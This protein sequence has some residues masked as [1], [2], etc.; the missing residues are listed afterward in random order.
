[1]VSVL[2]YH[3]KVRSFLTFIRRRWRRLFWWRWWWW[4]RKYWFCLLLMSGFLVF[5]FV[6]STLVPFLLTFLDVS[7]GLAAVRLIVR[8]DVD[9]SAHP[10]SV[11]VID[12][13]LALRV[14]LGSYNTRTRQMIL[15]LLSG[16]KKNPNS[17]VLKSKFTLQ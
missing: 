11:I 4:L 7:R 8:H 15:A 1:M 14:R 2:T 3:D 12:S 6:Q 9:I 16:A 17:F 10:G 13:W 5:Q